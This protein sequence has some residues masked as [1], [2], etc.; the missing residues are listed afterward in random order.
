M[1]QHTLQEIKAF[2]RKSPNAT[3]IVASILLGFILI[4]FGAL[5]QGCEGAQLQI[6]PTHPPVADQDGGNGDKAATPPPATTQRSVHASEPSDIEV[7][8]VKAK[9]DIDIE[10][11]LKIFNETLTLTLKGKGQGE[12]GG[13]SGCFDVSF[14]WGFAK[15]TQSYPKGCK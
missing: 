7:V 1:M 12:D 10:V 11:I 2:K 15:L 3:L 9:G 14:A 5:M 4:L 8:S 6:S 13:A